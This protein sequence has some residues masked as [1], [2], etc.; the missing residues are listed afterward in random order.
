MAIRHGRGMTVSGRPIP[1]LVVD[2]DTTLGTLVKDFLDGESYRVATASNYEQAAD[3]LAHVRFRLVVTD[4]LRDV[5][6]GLGEPRAAVGRLRD[7]A[8]D[9]GVVIVTAH[10]PTDVDG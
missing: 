4:A 7:L 10:R 3:A 1:V 6:C 5:A 2:D 8:R 9:A